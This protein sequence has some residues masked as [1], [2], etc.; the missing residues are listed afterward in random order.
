MQCE[1]DTATFLKKSAEKLLINLV[2]VNAYILSEINE[3]KT[4]SDE[5]LVIFAGKDAFEEAVK[6][7][8]F[9]CESIIA[10]RSV[11]YIKMDA[12][13]RI[14]VDTTVYV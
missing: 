14:P 5:A 10:N 12:I 9:N 1:R 3:K 6:K 11:N 13:F 4:L 7:L 2:G 8:D